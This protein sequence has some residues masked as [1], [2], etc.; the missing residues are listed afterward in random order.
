MI[1]SGP[2]TA[3]LAVGLGNPLMADDG[4]GSAV[5]GALQEIALP[6]AVSLSAAPDILS[7]NSFWRGQATVWLFDAVERGAPP[8]TLHFVDHDEVMQLRTNTASTHHLDFGGGLRWLLHATPELRGVRFLLWGAEP[9]RVVPLHG[10][11]P[12]VEAA[13]GRVVGDVLEA[14]RSA[15]NQTPDA[16]RT[17]VPV[18]R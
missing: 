10:L 13:V 3:I 16:A 7:L 15:H 2:D 12:R 4:F 6:P 11:C 9:E 18:A 1:S 5:I 17:R 14:I 8:G